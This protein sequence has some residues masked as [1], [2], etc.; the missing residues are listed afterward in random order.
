[1]KVV[2]PVENELAAPVV[3]ATK[4]SWL[5]QIVCGQSKLNAVTERNF[6]YITRM[7]KRIISL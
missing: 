4:E 3:F 5:T 1:M 2:H 7:D 6:Y